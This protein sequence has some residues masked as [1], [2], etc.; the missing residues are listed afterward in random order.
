MTFALGWIDFIFEI[1]RDI[2]K[3][4]L[5]KLFLE[6]EEYKLERDLIL[7]N[8]YIFTSYKNNKYINKFVKENRVNLIYSRENNKFNIQLL[9]LKN[10]NNLF[11]NEIKNN[12]INIKNNNVNLLFLNWITFNIWDFW[13]QTEK[14]YKLL[15]KESKDFWYKKENFIKAWNFIEDILI[16]Y[17]DFNS[18]RDKH[19]LKEDIIWNFPAW[20]GIDCLL[21]SQIKH[22]SSYFFLKDLS[23]NIEIESVNSNLQCEAY[24]YWPKFS[25]AK[26]IKSKIDNNDILFIS[27]T[28]A[29][30]KNWK[31]IYTD[32]I[33]ENIKY[34]FN[35]IEN[36]LKKAWMN[37]D[38][39]V[40]AF[41][42]IKH[43]NYYKT[44]LDIYNNSN[45]NF[46]YIYNFCDICRDDFLFEIECI[47][48]KKYNK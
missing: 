7:V 48:V 21:P 27:W 19:F 9:F 5:L 20:T 15:F 12:W 37:F 17:K 3:E 36:L 33:E 31:S 18:I 44:F 46:S 25:R 8:S 41:I 26:L 16:R 43:K 13:K 30:D 10:N 35:S 29:V 24:D 4:N 42:Y 34:T 6:I 45:F 38:N 47:A 40:S 22:S 2:N 1:K 11:Y 39:I 28:A 23:K 14:T 32:D